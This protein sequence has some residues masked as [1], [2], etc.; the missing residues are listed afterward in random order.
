MYE[1]RTPERGVGTVA[2]NGSEGVAIVVRVIYFRCVCIHDSSKG[3]V[4]SKRPGL[5]FCPPKAFQKADCEVLDFHCAEPPSCSVPKV[6]SS[7]AEFRI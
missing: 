4:F 2:R 7:T 1:D 5:L 3:P 6:R